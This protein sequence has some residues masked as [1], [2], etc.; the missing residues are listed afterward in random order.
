MYVAHNITASQG[1]QV[2]GVYDDYTKAKDDLKTMMGWHEET[3][4]WGHFIRI[5]ELNQAFGNVLRL[6][7][8]D[9]DGKPYETKRTRHTIRRKSTTTR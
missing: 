9:K 3:T 4:D 5:G 1:G 2:I 8:T 7:Q 6:P